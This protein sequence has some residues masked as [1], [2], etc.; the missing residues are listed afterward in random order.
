MCNPS[1]VEFIA[2]LICFAREHCGIKRGQFA[3]MLDISYQNL[4]DIEHGGHKVSGEYLD[5]IIERLPLASLEF[6]ALVPHYIEQLK[7]PENSGLSIP[8]V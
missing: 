2:G 5:F 7:R 6:W 3:A 8:L 4:W 1:S